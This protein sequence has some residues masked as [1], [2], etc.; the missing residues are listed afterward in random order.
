MFQRQMPP[1]CK[2]ADVIVLVTTPSPELVESETTYARLKELGC[3][4][5]I[6]LFNK[7]PRPPTPSLHRSIAPSLHH[8]KDPQLTRQIYLNLSRWMNPATK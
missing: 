8:E 4:K 6:A 5:K 1:R 2:L 7:I 3:A